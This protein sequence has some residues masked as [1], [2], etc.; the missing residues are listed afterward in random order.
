M[1][2]PIELK[3]IKSKAEYKKALKLIEIYFDAKAES[4]E[5]DL[6]EILSILVE[7]YEEEHFPIDPPDP[8]EAIKFRMEQLG[9]EIKDIARLI[10]SKS[11]T[12]EIL[13]RKRSLSLHHIRL[14]NR[15]LGVPAESLIGV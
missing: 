3:P 12:S 5:G 11:H 7:K 8:V 2:K 4:K 15:K 1:K 14:L 10:G 9:L 6:L 13:N